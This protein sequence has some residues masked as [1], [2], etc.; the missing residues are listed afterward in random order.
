MKGF[1]RSYA[2]FLGLDS[3]I[4]LEKYRDILGEKEGEKKEEEKPKPPAE[5]VVLLREIR[6]SLKN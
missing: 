6:D 3:T 4:V 1:L 2:D 5:E